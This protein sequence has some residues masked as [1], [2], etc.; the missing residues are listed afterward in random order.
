[1][2]RVRVDFSK[3]IGKIKPMHATNNGPIKGIG[4]GGADANGFVMWKKAGIP[5]ARTHDSSFCS[6]YGGEHTVDVHAVFPDFNAD[7]NN[8][9]SYDFVVTDN[10]LK[11]I[12]ECGSKVFYR[13]GTKIEHEVKKYNTLP[14]K[15]FKKWA[16]ICEHIIM[17]YTEGWADGFKY[18]IKYWEIWNEPDL[19][20]EDATNKRTWGGTNAQFYEFYEIAATHLKSRFPS[21]KIG[22]PASAYREEWI[23]G[24]FKHLT[25]NGKKIPLDFFSWHCYGSTVEKVQNRSKWVREKLNEYGYTSTE[26]IL[27]EWNYIKSWDDF[28]YSVRHITSIKGAAFEAAL[29]CNSQSEGLI[30]MLMYYDARPSSYNGLFDY[31]TYEPLKGYYPFKMFNA[32]YELENACESVVDS[33]N[34]YLAAAKSEDKKAVMIAYFT[35]D[36]SLNE[37]I[38]IVLDFGEVKDGFEVILLDKEHNAESVENVKSGSK[39]AIAP[40]TVCLLECVK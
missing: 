11:Q 39:I 16:E 26:S 22:G 19:D 35:D 7:V 38:D 4:F 12:T 6:S 34:I 13:L 8:P 32:L 24:F 1:M 23:E 21:L 2:A 15:D 10:Y 20:P 9:S 5:Y 28:A 36:D 29:M 40:N 27:N 14:P 25:S 33:E 30:D 18:D 3:T 17:H 31:Y 37:S